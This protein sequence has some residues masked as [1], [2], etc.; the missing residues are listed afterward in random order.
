MLLRLGVHK[1]LPEQFQPVPGLSAIFPEQ[2]IHGLAQFS[3]GNRLH[4]VIKRT[5]ADRIDSIMVISR[6]KNN[7]EIRLTDLFDDL[8]TAHPRHFDIQ[9]HDIRSMMPDQQDRLFRLMGGADHLQGTRKLL[10]LL[11]EVLQAARFVVY[12]YRCQ[13]IHIDENEIK[14]FP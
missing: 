1:G 2:P 4:Q 9:E 12:Q 8:E 6:N 10:Q 7:L 14:Q 11:P 3:Q 13:S 5:D